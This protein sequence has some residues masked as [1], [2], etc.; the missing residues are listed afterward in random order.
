M[1]KSRAQRMHLVDKANRL[2]VIRQCELI[3]VSRS[4]FYYKPVA[5]S[6]LNL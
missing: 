2:S 3:G 5:E 6:E 1:N 4:S